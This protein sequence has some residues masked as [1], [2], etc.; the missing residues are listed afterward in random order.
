[1][2][3]FF[4]AYIVQ[5][6]TK[7]TKNSLTP[8][9]IRDI[10][11]I[12]I[13]SN[14]IKY[15]FIKKN[16]EKEGISMKKLTFAAAAVLMTLSFAAVTH[17]E[18]TPQQPSGSGTW[19]SPY[20]ISSAENLYW[21]AQYCNSAED[22]SSCYAELSKDVVI[23]SGTVNSNTTEKDAEVWTPIMN[24]GG[25]FNGKDHTISGLYVRGGEYAGLFGSTK[26]G[27]T[28][29]D[30]VIDNSFIEGTKY[31]G[32]IVAYNEA[33]Y[34]YRCTNKAEV[35]SVTEGAYTGGIVG[36]NAAKNNFADCYNYGNITG[37]DYTGGV[38]GASVPA[39]SL[40][41]KFGNYGTVCG[42]KYTGGIIGYMECTFSKTELS[43]CFN[44]GNV[45]ST[46]YAGGICG[47]SQKNTGAS[48]TSGGGGMIWN[49]KNTVSNSFNCGDLTAEHTSGISGHDGESVYVNNCCYLSGTSEEDDYEITVLVSGKGWQTQQLT[50]GTELTAEEFASGKA[51]YILNGES[52]G[53][54]SV[55]RQELGS[56]AYP[57][58]TAG[59]LVYY[60]V[61]DDTYSNTENALEKTYRLYGD[62]NTD[63]Y[64][65]LRDV[66]EV[67]KKADSA[68]YLMPIETASE[69][70]SDVV[71]GDMTGDGYVTKADAELMLRIITLS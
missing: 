39:G 45:Y 53:S 51:A 5:K 60:S 46:E 31:T 66:I 32:A 18:I 3:Q 38:I 6:P 17:A 24:F 42:T 59:S 15:Y 43:N 55:W 30:I 7:F 22:T 54:G 9:I 34:L 49:I 41:R 56:D 71:Y 4:C 33:D 57:S 21:F 25:Q 58:M 47:Y 37:T 20:S 19:R 70:S 69:A 44:F 63:N 13:V 36:Y 23:N 10:I 61:L 50:L 62:V 67:L 14:N 64:T 52:T 48:G 1:M 35:R 29:E 40:L 65:D 2:R 8:K 11:Y 68:D 28:V 26:D 16:G 12:G 27:A